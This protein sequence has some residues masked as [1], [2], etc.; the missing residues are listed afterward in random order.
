MDKESQKNIDEKSADNTAKWLTPEDPLKTLSIG[1]EYGIANSNHY[2]G[3]FKTPEE[4]LEHLNYCQIRRQEKSVAAYYGEPKEGCRVCS[5]SQLMQDRILR[6]TF[7]YG[8]PDG[9]IKENILVV[10]YMDYGSTAQKHN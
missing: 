2:C 6:V 7:P 9:M 3:F 8:T 4:A 10:Q 5:A 1:K